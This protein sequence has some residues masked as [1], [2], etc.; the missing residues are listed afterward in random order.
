MALFSKVAMLQLQLLLVVFLLGSSVRVLPP[1]EANP[2][3]RDVYERA[4]LA[5][6]LLALPALPAGALLLSVRLAVGHAEVAALAAGAKAE[7]L[8]S[9][10]SPWRRAAL[11]AT[12]LLAVALCT[13][14]SLLAAAAYHYSLR[15]KSGCAVDM[16]TGILVPVQVLALVSM[17]TVQCH[18]ASAAVSSN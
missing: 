1:D 14:S 2:C 6:R 12:L 10:A 11:R 7:G 16:T 18:F 5:H 3:G 8:A 4:V 17:V 13:A 15:Y 9:V